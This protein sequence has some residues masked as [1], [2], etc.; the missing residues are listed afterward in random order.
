MR[1]HPLKIILDSN[2]RRIIKK[3]S[4]IGLFGIL[5]NSLMGLQ[6]IF[7]PIL[8]L[9]WCAIN[10]MENKERAYALDFARCA[11][12]VALGLFWIFTNWDFIKILFV[13]T[14]MAWVWLAFEAIRAKALLAFAVGKER[15]SKMRQNKQNQAKKAR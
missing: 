6:I 1:I 4:L 8:G 9:F 3:I 5:L 2:D 14:A 15:I 7:L 13:V 12:L 10:W 11:A